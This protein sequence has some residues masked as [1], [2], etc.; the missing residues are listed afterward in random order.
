LAF[1]NVTEEQIVTFIQ[2]RGY[3]FALQVGSDRAFTP[4]EWQ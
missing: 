4:V 3:R 1:V 2:D